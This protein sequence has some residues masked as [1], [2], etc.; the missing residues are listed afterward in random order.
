MILL[1]GI[2]DNHD[3]KGSAAHRYLQTYPS[4]P[5]FRF[6]Y[7]RFL[8][9]FYFCGSY[10]FLYCHFPHKIFFFLN[11]ISSPEDIFHKLVKFIFYSDKKVL[12]LFR[13]LNYIVS[14]RFDI[15]NLRVVKLLQSQYVDY[16]FFN[17]F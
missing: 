16:I 2:S 12:F 1:I 11:N 13:N 3:K 8:F 9:S 6:P 15:F 14:L 5:K 10:F 7:T 4:V 17:I